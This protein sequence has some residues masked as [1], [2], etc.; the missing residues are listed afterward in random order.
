MTLQERAKELLKRLQTI[1]ES[2]VDAEKRDH[3]TLA[4]LEQELRIVHAEGYISGLKQK[5]QDEK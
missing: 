1:E 3:E 5:G 2:V 4:L